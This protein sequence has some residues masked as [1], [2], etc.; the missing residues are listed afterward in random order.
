MVY[1]L[2][3]GASVP[4]TLTP[5]YSFCATVTSFICTD[6]AYPESKLTYAGA[7]SGTPYN[8]TSFMAGTTFAGGDTSWNSGTVY[9][10]RFSGGAWQQQVLL[11]FTPSA[12]LQ[13]QT[14]LVMDATTNVLW[15]TTSIGGS[16]DAGVAFTL[17][18]GHHI[19]TSP[20]T[21]AIVYNFCWAGSN[22][23]TDGRAP[24]GLVR[25]ASGN[26]YGAGG[27]G[28]VGTSP[29][30]GVVF[31]LTNGNCSENGVA[32]FWCNTALYDFCSAGT[33]GITPGP[34]SDLVMDGSGNLYG[35][36]TNGGHASTSNSGVVY[37]LSGSTQTVLHK[38]CSQTVNCADGEYPQSGVILDSS[39]N[40]YGTAA[41]G[42]TS[43]T[44]G[45]G[46]VYEITP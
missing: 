28:G 13:P 41:W 24:T 22:P 34:Y 40:L 5:I 39:G 19:W 35:T 44:S 21:E 15:G 37:E 12:G 30:N 11:P 31:E 29:G 38:F 3:K 1:K 46:V 20:W 6:G 45:S 42:G 7:E 17:T 32:G 2:T 36:T 23:C 18:P 25:D 33:C 10:V 26:L 9:A 27:G 14:G 16:F 43:S 4:W 8:G